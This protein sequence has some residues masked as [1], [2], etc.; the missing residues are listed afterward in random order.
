M[1]RGKIVLTIMVLTSILAG[2]NQKSTADVSSLSVSKA[3]EISHQIVGKFEQDYY[4]ED[5]LKELAASRVEEYCKENGEG[6]VALESVEES[7]GKVVI[8]LHY[9]SDEDYSSF[10]HRELFSGTVAQ[11][12]EQGYKL[13]HVA[14]V[15]AD[16]QPVEAGGIEG[17]DDMS[18]VI[19]ATKPSEEL[20]VNVYNKVLYINQGEVSGIDMAFDGKKSIHITNPASEGEEDSILSYIIF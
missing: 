4:E 19:I 11:A 20:V 13:D 14:L 6:G 3:G 1:R 17:L 5:G 15:S 18:I 2:C 10:N 12:K 9:L 7:G 16:K 8:N